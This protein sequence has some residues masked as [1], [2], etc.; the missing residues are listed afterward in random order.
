MSR[1]AGPCGP[2][3]L[4]PLLIGLGSSGAACP[5]RGRLSLEVGAQEP[6]SRRWAI[7]CSIT[8]GSGRTHPLWKGCFPAR[9]EGNQPR[10]HSP[11]TLHLR[12]FPWR[13]GCRWGPEG[14]PCSVLG[15]GAALLLPCQAAGPLRLWA[16]PAGRPLELW[17]SRD[18]SGVPPKAC[19]GQSSH[20]AAAETLWEKPPCLS[21]RQ[22]LLSSHCCLGS[23]TVLPPAMPLG[24]SWGYLEKPETSKIATLTM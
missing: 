11:S 2:P 6:D 20:R 4:S 9:L 18:L 1:E 16:K 23:V 21:P 13:T 14:S 3:W 22:N 15:W 12:S 17:F 24:S 10:I 8:L 19:D 7:P 5:G